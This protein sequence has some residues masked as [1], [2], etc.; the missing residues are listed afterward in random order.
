MMNYYESVVFDY[1]RA[2]RTVFL[3]TEYCIQINPGDNPDTSGPHWY[4]DAVALKFQAEEVKI[5][6]VEISYAKNLAG[7]IKRLKDWND[8]WEGVCA[9]LVRDSAFSYIFATSW[10]MRPWLFVP[11][12]LVCFLKERLVQIANGQPLKF[13][14]EIT[15]L[16]K[17]VPWL[18][19]AHNRKPDCDH[20]G[21]LDELH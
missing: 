13:D 17:V 11:E 16:E 6:L 5:F 2:D 12:H 20:L 10:S 7:L 1:L 9:A 3:N 21:P 8:N 19:P 4:C 14:Y 18:F 15:P